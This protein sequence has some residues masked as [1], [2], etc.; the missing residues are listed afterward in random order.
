MYIPKHFQVTDIQKLISFIKE[1]SFGILFSQK[2]GEPFATHL[3]FLIEQDECG[4]F[5]L[6]GHM[7]KTNPHWEY[8]QGQ[9]LVVFQGPH[10]YISP[11][12]YQEENAVPTWNYAT[13]HVYGEF[14]LVDEQDELLRILHHSIQQ[15]ESSMEPPWKTDLFNEFNRQLMKMIVGFKI[16]INRFEGKWKLN[17]HHSVERR[18]RLIDG[19]RKMGDENSSKIADLIEQ[20]ILENQKAPL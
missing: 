16:K 17:Q 4:Q 9:V 13:V 8:I 19:L 10:A 6:L 15:Y 2:D 1:Y 14:I 11:T 7:A 12:W 20:T 5:Y 18:K 3:P